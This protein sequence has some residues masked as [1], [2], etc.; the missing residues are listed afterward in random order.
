[1]SIK[2]LCLTA[3]YA[4]PEVAEICLRGLNRLR[5][6]FD[7]QPLAVYTGD[8]A[9]LCKRYDV[10]GLE[11]KN[12][13]LGEKWNAGLTE[14]LKHKW[15]YLMT[16]GSDDLLANELLRQYS[17]TEESF[18]ITECGV[19]DLRTGEKRIFK[20]NYVLGVGRCIR[21]DV[22]DGLEDMVTIR[23]RKSA[24]GLDF[25]CTARHE[26]VMARKFAERLSGVADII[27]EHSL[28]IKLWP[29]NFNR[30]LDHASECLLLRNGIR[31]TKVLTTSIL[32]VDL[33]S[34]VNIWPIEQYER[35]TF[36]LNWISQGEQDAIRQ[37]TE[38]H[39]N[40][41]VHAH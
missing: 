22:I 36:E 7:I 18:G 16:I 41:R 27:H 6:E 12:E 32:A 1:M 35:G 25:K 40:R 20:N 34:D 28:D 8:F 39:K 15:D 19:L 21:R 30:G 26:V 24:V 29:D 4:R 5:E 11:F 13:P 14:A 9:E 2:V 33:K 10:I 31:Q 37:F 3:L 23:Y 38:V 17:W